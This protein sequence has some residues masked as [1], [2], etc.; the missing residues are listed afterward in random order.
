MAQATIKGTDQ[1]SAILE[2]LGSNS[3]D[4]AGR[5]L[6]KGASVVYDSMAAGVSSIQVHQRGTYS[7]PGAYGGVPAEWKEGLQESLG[8]AP[9]RHS[10]GK[11]DTSVGFDGYNG[12]STERYPGGMPNRM[13]A[14]MVEK[15][16]SWFPPQPVVSK[17]GKSARQAAIAAMEKQ[18]D[19]EIKKYTKG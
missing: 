8:I 1:I 10:G 2:A 7:A 4:I 18:A 19:E 11:T 15:G 3:Q 5:I 16:G 13:V 6:Y 14:R 9:H 12:I 17:A